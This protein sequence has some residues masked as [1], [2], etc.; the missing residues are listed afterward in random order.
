MFVFGANHLMLTHHLTCSFLGK[1]IS[2]HYLVAYSSLYK[3]EAYGKI[4][5]ER[6]VKGYK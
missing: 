5:K 1:T 3:R 6:K 4:K 2:K